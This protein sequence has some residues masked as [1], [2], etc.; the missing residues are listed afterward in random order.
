MC[1]YISFL[2]ELKNKKTERGSK[3]ISFEFKNG[4]DHIQ[5]SN[6]TDILRMNIHLLIS[7]L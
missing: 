6:L 2:D 1:P 3:S 7:Y 5:I 4:I